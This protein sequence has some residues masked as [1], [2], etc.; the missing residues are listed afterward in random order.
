M[1]QRNIMIFYE[2]DK[3][4]FF[5]PWLEKFLY[6]RGLSKPDGRPLY[7]YQTT[8]EEYL[9]LEKNLNY[10]SSEG[11]IN[12]NIEFSAC[13][14]LFCAEW[15]RREYRT[16]DGWSW[17][18]IWKKLGRKIDPN[19]RAS[20]VIDGLEY[21]WKRKVS[22]YDSDRRNLLGSVFIEGGLPF[23]CLQDKESKFQDFF[24]RVLKLYKNYRNI[25][26]SIKKL[27]SDIAQQVILPQAFQVESSQDF[28][29]NMADE[30]VLLV[31]FYNL[32]E[33]ENPAEELDRL[34]PSW[35]D[36]FPIP[37][38]IKVGRDFINSLL[39]SASKETKKN[40]LADQVL[41]CENFYCELKFN[42]IY[43]LVY[44][45]KILYFE[46]CKQV[47]SSR[48]EI[49]IFEE[50][51]LLINL[52]PCYIDFS[53]RG[54]RVKNN[55]SNIRVKRN[56]LQSELR[57]CL[58][59]HGA[60]IATQIIPNS[61]IDLGSV[62]LG[63]VPNEVG[64]YVLVGQASFSIKASKFHLWVPNN[65][66][67]TFEE[68]NYI[69][70]E[71]DVTH[72]NIYEIYGTAQLKIKTEEVFRVRLNYDSNRSLSVFLRG[73]E[74]SWP[75]KPSTVYLGLPNPT[76]QDTLGTETISNL[77]F[78]LI[79]SG[80]EYD[81]IS[82]FENYGV[83]Y[84]AVRSINNEALFRRKVGILPEDF[85]LELESGDTPYEGIVWIQTEQ[86]GYYEVIEKNLENY[87]IY[88]ENDP[89]YIGI[90]ISANVT[91]HI[92]Y[93]FNLRVQ[94][95]TSE[96]IIL[97]LPFPSSGFLAFD[98]EGNKLPR[99]LSIN[100]LL[101]SRLYL[102][103]RL[104]FKSTKYEL[105]LI[106]KGEKRLSIHE[107]W[108][109]LVDSEPIEISLFMLKDQIEQLLSLQRGID[110]YVELTVNDQLVC[111]IS[112]YAVDLM[113]NASRSVV[114]CTDR[115]YTRTQYPKPCLISLTNPEEKP[116]ELVPYTSQGIDFGEYA[117]PSNLDLD[118]VWL[119]VPAKDSPVSFRP[120]LLNIG[121][122][123]NN[124]DDSFM[125]LERFNNIR[126]AVRYF[127]PELKPTT[128]DRVIAQM[129]QQ[130]GHKGW[131]YI[132]AL[133]ENYGY[134]PLATFEA[135]L[136]LMQNKRAIAM[137]IFKF[138]MSEVLIR[139]LAERFPFAWE[140]YPIRQ[141]LY[142]EQD[143]F[144]YL[145]TK[146]L[147]VDMIPKIRENFYDR[148]A[149][150]VP[151]YS[152][153]ISTW[154][155]Y[156]RVDEKTR[157]ARSFI[158]QIMP[159]WYQSLLKKRSDDDFWPSFGGNELKKWVKSQEN[160]YFIDTEI[161]SRNTVVY[162]PIF[163]AAV[164]AEQV[165]P[166]IIFPSELE[167]IFYLRRVRDFDTEWFNGM[168]QYALLSYLDS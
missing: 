5:S 17:D 50:S 16:E 55:I 64:N 89:S 93:T 108:H 134:L 98:N 158:A 77:N 68:G 69:P 24:I 146:G 73:N 62:P 125:D 66:E 91:E 161:D 143:F 7:E 127:N 31:D 168:Y 2:K 124:I 30:L 132:R 95:G 116:I 47:A 107:Y 26:Y 49:A 106:L 87:F 88:D 149:V 6:S 9:S 151:V 92:P 162:L 12:N 113:I 145:K 23:Q 104:G 86:E 19:D 57:I 37:L 137:A 159:A 13:F 94:Y 120:E 130:P 131:L 29:A 63:F 34:K 14:V 163:A 167:L 43:S 150:S 11:D 75:S 103:G 32:S 78:K 164:A 112:R 3:S 42:E 156:Q 76:V 121:N 21:Y 70:V 154:L 74:L 45:P 147:P 110:R 115:H 56:N 10:F 102:F 27:V 148:L 52:G 60:E 40:N 144:N 67:V 38:D 41:K 71:S 82:D 15:Y 139:R 46:K 101:G 166:N 100:E 65:A 81:S 90:Y 4:Y 80:I 136:A 83:H 53:D 141:F 152:G 123:N 18:P 105:G 126:W 44:F 22:V 58:L 85:H 33:K 160:I 36:G 20:T 8:H 54:L 140:T 142:A 129:S 109:V 51:S 153:V 61:F 48:L 117:L 135:W 25:G 96:S 122:K 72:S 133:Y 35:R 118:R 84:I 157:T 39:I 28:L 119:I 97:S 114:S 155:K 128:L 138:E 79:V 1:V 99:D 59:F 165:D 111:R